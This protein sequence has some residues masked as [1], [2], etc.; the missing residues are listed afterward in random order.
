ML[1]FA[2][3]YLDSACTLWYS[4]RPHETKFV[5]TLFL[6]AHGI[7]LLTKDALVASGWRLQDLREKFRHNVKALWRT[8]EIAYLRNEV[9][10]EAKYAWE[11]AA[12]SDIFEDCFKSDPVDLIDE[13]IDV[14][15]DLHSSPGYELRYGALSNGRK[16]PQPNLLIDSF[17]PVS[18]RILRE[19]T[20]GNLMD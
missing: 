8:D 7:E 14:I 18:Q 20:R 3:A 10:I 5:P 11:Q 2:V 9:Y 6:I 16:A 12:K 13:Y 4:D 1:L 17:R 19:R 15:S